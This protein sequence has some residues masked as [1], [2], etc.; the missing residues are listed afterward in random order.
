MI[1]LPVDYAYAFDYFAILEI[2]YVKNIIPRNTFAEVAGAIAAQVGNKTFM[3]IINSAEYANLHTAN[4]KTFDAVDKAK[5]DEVK[6]S[7]VDQCNT[8]RFLAKR[9][10]QKKFFPEYDLKEIKMESI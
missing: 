7:Y 1:N 4:S 5:K 3:Q 9:A 10:L 8:E 6:A 2:K